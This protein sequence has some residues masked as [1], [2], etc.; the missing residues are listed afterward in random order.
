MK[1]DKLKWTE[2]LNDDTESRMTKTFTNGYGM[3]VNFYSD[4]S[5]QSFFDAISNLECGY[6]KTILQSLKQLRLRN[7]MIVQYL[8][9]SLPFLDKAIEQEELNEKKNQLCE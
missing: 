9:D 5:Y 1:D 2:K 3:T 7:S 4:G 8:Q 6:G